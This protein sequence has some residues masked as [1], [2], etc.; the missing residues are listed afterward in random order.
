[1]FDALLVYFGGS[2]PISLSVCCKIYNV[3]KKLQAFLY[4]GLRIMINLHF[5]KFKER[6][7]KKYY[8]THMF[9]LWSMWV[10]IHVRLVATHDQ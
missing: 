1:M 5:K 3:K 4:V 2:R 6:M 9:T 10:D 7:G 8:H